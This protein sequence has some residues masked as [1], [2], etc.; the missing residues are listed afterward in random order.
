MEKILFI[1]IIRYYFLLC[2]TRN[3]KYCMIICKNYI[4]FWSF[5]LVNTKIDSWCRFL[6][7]CFDAKINFDDNAEYRQKDIFAMDDNSE[8]D[9]RE[10][11]AGKHNLNYVGM[12]GSIGCLGNYSSTLYLYPYLGL[13][14]WILITLTLWILFCRPYFTVLQWKIHW[15]SKQLIGNHKM[16]VYLFVTLDLTFII[17]SRRALA[18]KGDYEMMS[19]CACVR[20]CVRVLVSHADFSKTTTATDFL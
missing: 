14:Y 10:L 17:I 3:T 6:V 19:V 7:V 12:E 16:A 9:P 20:A 2:M 15:M 1:N 13:Q 11:E 8:T 4:F 5:F 18:R